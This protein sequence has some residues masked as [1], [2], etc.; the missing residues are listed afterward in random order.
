MA[1]QTSASTSLMN[2][3][4]QIMNTKMFAGRLHSLNVNKAPHKTD[5]CKN[6]NKAQFGKCT[7]HTTVNV[8]R[9]K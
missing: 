4:K 1:E 3:F 6:I 5:P 8:Y 7:S 9:L 2:Q